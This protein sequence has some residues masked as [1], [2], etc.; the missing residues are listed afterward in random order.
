MDEGQVRVVLLIGQPLMKVVVFKH[1]GPVFQTNGNIDA[2]VIHGI[3][4][5]WTE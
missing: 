3:K 2:N 5:G 1:L 4:V